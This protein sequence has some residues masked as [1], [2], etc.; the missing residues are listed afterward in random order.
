MT[1]EDQIASLKAERAANVAPRH[2]LEL[3]VRIGANDLMY[4][5][6]AVAE[7]AQHVDERKPGEVGCASGCPDGCYSIDLAARDVAPE[8]YKAELRAW[9]ERDGEFFREIKRLTEELD[10][11]SREHLATFDGTPQSVA[12]EA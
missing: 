2:P 9:S 10:R 4:L 12:K 6:Q 8:Q 11:R 3:T 1:L 5:R 7:V